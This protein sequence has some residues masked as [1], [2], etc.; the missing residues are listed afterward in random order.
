MKVVIR[1]LRWT[2]SILLILVGLGLSVSWF[3]DVRQ[4]DSELTLRFYY[5]LMTKNQPIEKP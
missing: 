1:V 3:I 4:S 2:F 5:S